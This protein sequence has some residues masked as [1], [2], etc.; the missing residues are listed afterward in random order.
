[1]STSRTIYLKGDLATPVKLVESE[2]L[3]VIRTR[4]DCDIESLLDACK[5]LR[6][7]K[8]KIQPVSSFLDSNV[9]VHKYDGGKEEKDKIKSII[10]E[11]ISDKIDFCGH[12]SSI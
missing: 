6:P 4:E 11:E 2:N 8:D 12:P 7:Y 1:M 10:R 3:F 9:T 5:G